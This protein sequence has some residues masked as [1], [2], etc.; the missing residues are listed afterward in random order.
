MSQLVTRPNGGPVAVV[1]NGTLVSA[2]VVT[3]NRESHLR[4]CLSGLME[5]SIADRMEVILV[6]QGSDECE[7]AVA[8]D[9]QRRYGNLITLKVP[10]A[11]AVKAVN[12]ALK[13]ASGRYLTILDA[14][15]RMRRDAY[16]QLA[17]AL[18][19]NPTAMLAYGDTCFTAIPHENFAH[20]TSYGKVI[21]PDYTVQQLSQ[22][23]EVAPHPLWRRE[24]H[25]SIGFIPEGYPNHG[26]REFLLKTVERFRIQHIE[27]FTGL[28]LIAA[29]SQA[30]Q[31]EP[32]ATAMPVQEQFT[33]QPFQG[34]EKAPEPQAAQ[35]AAAPLSADEAY[36]NLKPLVS[37][38]DMEK[39]ERT[40]KEHLLRYPNHAV[41]HNDLAAVSY[42]LGDCEQ[43]LKHYREA[44]RLQPDEDVYLKNLADL[45][46]VETDAVDEAI[47]IY[48]KLLEKSPRDVE[49]L[50][51]LGIICEGVGQPAEAESFLQRVL[52][53]EPWNQ[54]ARER[55]KALREAAA[56]PAQASATSAAPA[57]ACEDDEL[58][59]EE[60]YEVSQQMVQS[61][62]RS[63]A[64][65]K[66]HRLIE[67]YP[68]FA[69][70]HNDL[71]VLAYEHGDTE[72]AR[73]HY[74]KAAQLRPG[75][76]TF[77][78]NLA[79]FYF[80]EGYDVDGAINIYLEELEKEPKNIETLMGLGRICTML[81]RP[82]EAETFYS[83]VINLEPWNREARES[84]N[85][86]KQAVNG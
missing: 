40:L 45:L 60:L 35:T 59:A 37:G 9:L 56:A 42:Q 16:E 69:P 68:D 77:R 13:M 58:T 78:K 29:S 3:R 27:E 28:K 26:M 52:E 20:H 54:A 39:A 70:A 47:S 65:T 23:S 7:W 74:E 71:A 46:Y 30:V 25:D 21:W 43:A 1:E 6:D 61:G 50:L 14:T 15:D 18:E 36:A 66:L 38:G 64:E 17:A 83:K 84:L 22:L 10:A 11:S 8:A 24:L 12:M 33:S 72:T 19:T 57:P 5:Q 44:V 48:L 49:A 34:F 51:N 86:L 4:E 76:G 79:D 85:S 67:L 32:R 81:D 80:V 63:G 41:A 62:N 75:N 31:S 2:I 73:I 82:E 55:L 53:I